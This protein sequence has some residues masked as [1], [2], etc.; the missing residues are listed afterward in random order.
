MEFIRNIPGLDFIEIDFH[1]VRVAA[2]ENSVRHDVFLVA[3]FSVSC[4]AS[5]R[6]QL[7]GRK[8]EGRKRLDSA[9]LL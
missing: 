1:R 5:S 4:G 9:P 6:F 7:R 2:I 3:S 8:R